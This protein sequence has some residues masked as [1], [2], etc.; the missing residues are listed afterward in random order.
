MVASVH[1]RWRLR[2]G[3]CRKSTSLREFHHASWG[4]ICIATQDYHVFGASSL[5]TSESIDQIHISKHI[6][7]VK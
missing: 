5:H 1:D 4:N 2:Q 3:C 6:T 7:H